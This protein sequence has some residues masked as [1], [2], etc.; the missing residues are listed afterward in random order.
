MS[1]EIRALLQKLRLHGMIAEFDRQILSNEINH[2]SFQDRFLTIL[3]AEQSFKSN[4]RLQRLL[5]KS[6]LKHTNGIQQ[7]D[8]KSQREL[9]S[10]LMLSLTALNWVSQHKNI[11]FTGPSGVGKTWLACALG[12]EAC[13]NGIPVLFK[14]VRIL[15]EELTAAKLSGAFHYKIEE[16]GKYPVLILDDW[17]IESYNKKEQSDLFE[18]I[19]SRHQTHST[20]ITS[21]MPI[22]SWHDAFSNKNLADSMLD[23]LLSTTYRIELS[24]DSLRS[25]N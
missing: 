14:K 18:L 1:N 12:H 11:S 13:L 19:D 5:K 7:I 16:I 22:P 10:S 6:G 9:D 15:L 3:S 4:Q 2:V 20:I 25:R 8:Y 24:G 17:A 21:L 23:R